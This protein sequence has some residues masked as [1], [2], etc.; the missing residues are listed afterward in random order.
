MENRT[1][2]VKINL[3]AAFRRGRQGIRPC[4]CTYTYTIWSA[5]YPSNEAHVADNTGHYARRPC[6]H[7]FH[8]RMSV[9]MD[10]VRMRVRAQFVRLLLL[11]RSG[12]C[13][14]RPP[15]SIHLG[16]F[17]LCRMYYRVAYKIALLLFIVIVKP[18]CAIL[19]EAADAVKEF[20]FWCFSVRC[21][22][23][24]HFEEYKTAFYRKNS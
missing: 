10:R 3:P 9:R 20:R 11:K 1:A 5:Q 24:R 6:F 18:R 4:S 22:Y 16:N 2:K 23:S 21:F 8:H 17:I 7:W 12:T 15:V 13:G 14:T 19:A